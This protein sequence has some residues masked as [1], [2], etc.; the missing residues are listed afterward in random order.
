MVGQKN[1][2]LGDASRHRSRAT[3]HGQ[4]REGRSG[5]R[6]SLESRRVEVVRGAII[7]SE[8]HG[9]RIPPRFSRLSA[10]SRACSRLRLASS[11]LG[12]RCKAF[13]K[14]SMAASTLPC[15]SGA[16][17]RLLCASHSRAESPRPFQHLELC[18]ARTSSNRFDPRAA[19]VA[20]SRGAAGHREL[21]DDR[22]AAGPVSNPRGQLGRRAL[23]LFPVHNRYTS[24]DWQW[25]LA[26]T[27]FAIRHRAALRQSQSDVGRR[28]RHAVAA[29]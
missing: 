28:R 19:V 12:L 22:G 13:S 4:R 2:P 20:G 29:G 16:T 21:T 14:C 7:G 11:K 15:K 17:P 10:I 5:G 23:C 8:D 24:E 9:V 26:E 27:D 25:L 3:R 1:Q 6:S 18:H